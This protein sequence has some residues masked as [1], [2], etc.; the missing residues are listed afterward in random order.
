MRCSDTVGVPDVAR[1]LLHNTDWKLPLSQQ[2]SSYAQWASQSAEILCLETCI[3]YM[4]QNVLKL[5]ISVLMIGRL[6]KE[7][8]MAVSLSILIAG[9][10]LTFWKIGT[11]RAFHAWL[12]KH[13]RVSVVSRDR[14]TDYSAAIAVTGREI[15]EVADRF[16]LSKNMS[17]CL[18]K[19]LGSHYDD[20]RKSV[21]HE[22]NISNSQHV[23]SRQVMFSEIK[24]LQA[25]GLNIA[26]IAKELDIA[27]QTVRKYMAA[28]T[29]P[30]RASKER[31]PYYLYDTYVEE[32]YKHGKDLR[33]IFL[34]IKG[35][36]FPG[37]LTPFYDH[38]CYLS[39]GHKGYRSKQDVE[40]MK[41]TP[42]E[43]REPLLPIRQISHIV[44][45]SIRKKKMESYESKLVEKMM[46][47]G[48]FIDIYDAASIFYQTIMGDD[49]DRLSSWLNTYAQ[50]PIAELR[51]FAYGIKMDLKAVRNAITEDIS[52]GIVEGYVN[53]LK[54]MK[55]DMYGRA[56]LE[57]L[58]RKM[59]FSN[60]CFN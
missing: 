12:D 34:D 55:R 21:R 43:E 47:F 31:I 32:A 25:D 13:P 51:S 1:L 15:T 56:S 19:V 8:H 29:L 53:K 22:D 28:D 17:D 24:E 59:V 39:D 36:G 26:R 10:S 20:Y 57:L 18:T 50:S 27:R 3:A 7:S 58:K 2:G 38:Y 54:A 48:W 9:Q 4:F 33:K 42:S 41:A 11:W 60:L 40:K 52:N 30:K 23:D 16:H 14:S 5:R 6:E 44:E 46:S 37:S 35:R 49:V 45:K